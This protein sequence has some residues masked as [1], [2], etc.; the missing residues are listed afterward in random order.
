LQK[1]DIFYCLFSWFELLI[2]KKHILGEKISVLHAKN[3]RA[4]LDE[5]C[6]SRLKGYRFEISA[7]LHNLGWIDAPHSQNFGIL[8]SL[9]ELGC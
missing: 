2:A 6:F 1:K 8:I 9:E 3:T 7:I 4:L 5:I